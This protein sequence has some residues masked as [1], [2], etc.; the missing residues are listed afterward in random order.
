M[1][2]GYCVGG[3]IAVNYYKYSSAWLWPAVWASNI[4]LIWVFV[5][6]YC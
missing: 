1:A 5:R 4:T 3:S 6:D 2:L